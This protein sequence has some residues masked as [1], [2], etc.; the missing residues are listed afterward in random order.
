MKREQ[1]WT[2]QHLELGL[3]VT[4]QQEVGLR[5]VL[6][7]GFFVQHKAL[8]RSFRPELLCRHRPGTFNRNPG[9]LLQQAQGTKELNSACT[10]HSTSIVSPS[11]KGCWP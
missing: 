4:A 10:T 3:L 5:S 9:R 8:L 6:F 11:K 1:I 2:S 7:R